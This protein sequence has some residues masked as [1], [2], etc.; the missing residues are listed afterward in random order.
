MAR[1]WVI[2]M[3]T[4]NATG[5][6]GASYISSIDDA[7]G[8]QSTGSNV[9][10][11]FGGFGSLLNGNETVR[12]TQAVDV[13]GNIAY[14]RFNFAAEWVGAVQRFRP[15]DLSFNGRGAKPQAAPNRT[16][17]DL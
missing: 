13:H 2:S 9:G 12:K 1:I 17:Y 10:T 11:T 8:M 3:N 5:E 6:I 4:D 16:G 14:D 7:A 15:Q